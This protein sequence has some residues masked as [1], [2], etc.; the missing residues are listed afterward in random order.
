MKKSIFTLTKLASVLFIALIAFQSCSEDDS[1][2]VTA[3]ANDGSLAFQNSPASNYILSSQTASNTAERFVW[4]AADFG[5]ETSVSYDLQSSTS[6][7]FEEVNILDT[8]TETNIAVTVGSLLAI[9]T[10]LGLDNDPLT[11]NI[12]GSA[13]NS[14]SIYVRVRAYIGNGG[15][16]SQELYS[17]VETINLTVLENTGEVEITLPMIAVPGAYQG[18]TPAV[19]P[20]LAAAEIGQTNYEGFVY[21]MDATNE[22]KFLSPMED[23]T[24]DWGTT[25]WGDDNTYTGKLVEQDEVNC[26]STET[27]YHLVKANTADLTYSIVYTSWG[28]IGNATPTGWDA[29]TDLVYDSETGLL[30]ITLMLTAGTDNAIKFR[31]NDAWDINFGDTGVD[32]SLEFGGDNIPAPETSG[33]Y[34]IT[35]DLTNPRAYTYTLEAL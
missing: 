18:W 6:P 7:N 10:N 32:G 35:L 23:G 1:L 25:D 34:K 15:A 19:A 21:F 5:T 12:D 30:S 4:S 31:A 11:T 26:K 22:F 28:V 13:N 29:D 9:A 2:T 27:G 33:M 16:N 17:N 3:A 24:F 14:G 20:T 8:S